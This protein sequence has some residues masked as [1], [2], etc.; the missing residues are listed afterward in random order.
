MCYSCHRGCLLLHLAG[1]TI[2]VPHP[3]PDKQGT[4]NNIVWDYRINYVFKRN[5]TNSAYLDVNQPPCLFS[6][7]ILSVGMIVFTHAHAWHWD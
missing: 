3:V 7:P 2:V 4:E 5:Y 6:L 1:S